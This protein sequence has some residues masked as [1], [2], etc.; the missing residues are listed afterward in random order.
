M[1]NDDEEETEEAPRKRLLVARRLDS[2]RT[3]R[4]AYER[5]GEDDGERGG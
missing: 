5:I 3:E 2:M 4:S 1:A